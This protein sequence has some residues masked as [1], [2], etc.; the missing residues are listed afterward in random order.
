MY[1]VVS[2]KSKQNYRQGTTK[3]MLMKS[4]EAWIAEWYHT[5]V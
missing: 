4:Y 1:V 3:F 2:A 5:R